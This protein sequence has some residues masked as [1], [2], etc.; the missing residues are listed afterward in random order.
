VINCLYIILLLLFYSLDPSSIVAYLSVF[1][2]TCL[3]GVDHL[4]SIATR[5]SNHLS[6]SEA[7]LH[8]H[9]N[10]LLSTA[11]SVP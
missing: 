8:S 10:E 6:K 2:D 1:F 4:K 11:V 3:P 9:V 5:V 7:T